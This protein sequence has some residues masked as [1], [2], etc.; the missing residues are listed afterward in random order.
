[1]VKFKVINETAI[2]N[3]ASN[4]GRKKEIIFTNDK[5]EK[6]RISILSESYKS[7]SHS[8]LYKWSETKGW[9][10]IID[11]NPLSEYNVD[12]SYSDNYSQTS[13]DKIVRDLKKIAETF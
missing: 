11:K 4:G 12:I 2:Q 5:N 1:M 7:Q 6:F 13:F 3:C 9:N 8:F 10:M